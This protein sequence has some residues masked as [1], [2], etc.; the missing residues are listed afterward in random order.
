MDWF[1]NL[2]RYW[3]RTLFHLRLQKQQT[4][5]EIKP[6]KKG[7]LHI[8][9]SLP[10]QLFL[11]IEKFNYIHIQQF[12]TQILRNQLIFADLFLL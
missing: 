8:N 11:S 12:R 4:S 2:A 9:I 5:G 7:K 3:S 6:D 10:N 1:H